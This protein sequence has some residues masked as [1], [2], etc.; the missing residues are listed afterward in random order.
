MLYVLYVY[1]YTYTERVDAKSN[2]LSHHYRNHR[3]RKKYYSIKRTYST[4]NLFSLNNINDKVS[5]QYYINTLS[6]K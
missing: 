4:I 6:D 3:V 1:L 5:I 2:W